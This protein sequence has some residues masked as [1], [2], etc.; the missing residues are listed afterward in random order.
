MD[1]LVPFAVVLGIGMLGGTARYLHEEGM[2]D[3]RFN[4]F[5]YVSHTIVGGFV[6]TIAG[7]LSTY[8]GIEGPLQFAIVGLAA[9][10]S[11][12]LLDLLPGLFSKWA[13]RKLSDG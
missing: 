5:R 12:E 11:R 7:F 13:Q 1:N 8:Y 9:M 10:S 3:G 4:G 6:A 2:H